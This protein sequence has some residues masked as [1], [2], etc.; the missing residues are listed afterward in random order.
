M[1]A[2]EPIA[3]WKTTKEFIKR[4]MVY[5]QSDLENK[6]SGKVIVSLDVDKDGNAYNHSVVSSFS[7]EASKEALEIAKL[8]LWKPG[9][10]D[11]IAKDMSTKIEIVFSAKNYMRQLKKS[12]GSISPDLKHPSS[13]SY[14]IYSTSETNTQAAICFTDPKMTFEKYVAQ[15]MVFPEKAKELEISGAV[16]LTF[17]V[18]RNGKTSN[19]VIEKSVGG[20]CDNEAV[21]LIENTVWYPAVRNDS[22]VRSSVTRDI[23]FKFG[24]RHFYEGNQY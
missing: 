8:I 18:E 13:E 23:I 20:G 22:L 10:I 4:Q 7:D 11:G 5:P 17:V 12:S 15:N 1:T 6:R 24:E 14:K 19:I 21:R 3:G 2:P 9:N 16:R